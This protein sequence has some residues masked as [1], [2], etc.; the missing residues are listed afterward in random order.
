MDILLKGIKLKKMDSGENNRPVAQ[1]AQK[2]G[3]PSGVF[4]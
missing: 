4:Q 2:G 1:K 3:D